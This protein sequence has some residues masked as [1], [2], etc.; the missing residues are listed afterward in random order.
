MSQLQASVNAAELRDN[1][2][3]LNEEREVDKR[4][5]K[6]TNHKIETIEQEIQALK[7]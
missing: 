1:I 2:A 5:L 3:V 6:D 7:M 4:R